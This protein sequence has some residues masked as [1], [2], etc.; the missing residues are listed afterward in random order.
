MP[1]APMIDL[2]RQARDGR[3]AVGYFE[4]WDLYSLEATIAAAERAQ[5]PVIIGIGGLSANHDWLRRYGIPAY[6]EISRHLAEQASVPV[7][8]LLNECDSLSEALTGI[9]Y[10]WN[11]LMMHT[12]GWSDDRLIADTAALVEAAHAAGLRGRGRD[13]RTGGDARRRAAR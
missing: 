2:L 3:Y 13:R 8:T 6:G 4:S 11:A 1:N 7:A 10:G 9:G 12:Q 5:S